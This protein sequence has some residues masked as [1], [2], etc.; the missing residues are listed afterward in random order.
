MDSSVCKCHKR[1]GSSK[2]STSPS[3]T[4][5]GDAPV[6]EDEGFAS[7]WKRLN[8][9]NHQDILN[10]HHDPPIKIRPTRHNS[11]DGHNDVA[12]FLRIAAAGDHP[13][14][15]AMDHVEASAIYPPSVGEQAKPASSPVACVLSSQSPASGMCPFPL[16]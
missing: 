9:G 3:T 4:F 6:G 8:T 16:S 5:Y 15:D 12:P 13:A 2:R 7:L 11:G 1:K 10:R 14:P